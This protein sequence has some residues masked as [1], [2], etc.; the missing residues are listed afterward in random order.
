VAGLGVTGATG[1]IG[2][3]M[4]AWG[5]GEANA[6]SATPGAIAGSLAASPTLPTNAAVIATAKIDANSTVRAPIDR[7]PYSNERRL[8]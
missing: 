4:M 8:F 7:P 5:S 2:L 3:G 6:I 1:A